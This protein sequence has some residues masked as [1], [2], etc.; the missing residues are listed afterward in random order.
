MSLY[1]WS[2][3]TRVVTVCLCIES[4]PFTTLYRDYEGLTEGP[5]DIPMG[6]TRLYLYHN[7]ITAL[8]DC[9]FCQ[10]TQLSMLTL[11]NNFISARNFLDQCDQFN[12]IPKHSREPSLFAYTNHL[13]VV[14][15]LYFI[16]ETLKYSLIWVVTNSLLSAPQ[17]LMSGQV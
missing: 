15:D 3:L 16:A 2:R 1:Q 10:Y 14:P 12:S 5:T 8:R 11:K 17:H 6:V 7:Y 9:R 4:R 13:V